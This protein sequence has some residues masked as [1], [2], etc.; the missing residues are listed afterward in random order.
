MAKEFTTFQI[1]KYKGK[2]V[3][4][5]DNEGPHVYRNQVACIAGGGI[6]LHLDA[7]RLIQQSPK[8]EEFLETILEHEISNGLGH[9]HN[10]FDHLSKIL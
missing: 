2:I 3:V 4:V 6:Y 5:S 10:S 8:S 7:Y 1:G 9:T